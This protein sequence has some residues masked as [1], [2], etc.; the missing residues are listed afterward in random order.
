MNIHKLPFCT[1]KYILLNNNLK[2]TV[3][4][5]SGN[6]QD[7][8]EKQ[9]SRPII[10]S[11]PTSTIPQLMKGF[12]AN[13]N[14]E[15]EETLANADFS[16]F[17]KLGLPLAY[18]RKDFLADLTNILKDATEQE[19]NDILNKLNITLIKNKSTVDY[20]GIIDLSQLSSADIEGKVL[21]IATRFIK[22]NS[23]LTD[24]E[25]LNK[26]LNSLIQG[27]P[28]FINIIGKQK[29]NENYS[30]DV[31]TLIILK[32]IINNPKYQN[33]SNQEKTCIKF[34]TI[35]HDIAKAENANEEDAKLCALY[36]KII[37]DKITLPYEIKDRII[38]GIWLRF[39][40]LLR[41][42]L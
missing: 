17:G 26:I 1:D 6:T 40:I 30:L 18:T 25:K 7:R 14:P 2:Q 4:F 42:E 19:K 15:I 24:D 34:A 23:I 16:Q 13:N 29:A 39:M 11:H 28:E 27:I 5:S 10:N 33:L 38:L 36:A 8:F 37:L 35:L 3:S 12:F 9:N 21:S 41:L 31:Y 20:N 32:E 22:E